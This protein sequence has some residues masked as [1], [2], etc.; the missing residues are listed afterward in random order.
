LLTA[1]AKGVALELERRVNVG[2]EKPPRY[3]LSDAE[4][5]AL[6]AEQAAL[7]ESLAAPCALTNK[8]SLATTAQHSG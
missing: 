6:L 5:D 3:H 2:M 1:A 8:R 7:I 4:K